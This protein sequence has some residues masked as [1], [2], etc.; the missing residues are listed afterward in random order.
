MKKKAA[1][2]VKSIRR[3]DLIHVYLKV[4]EEYIGV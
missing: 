2:G 1:A 3:K 4:E